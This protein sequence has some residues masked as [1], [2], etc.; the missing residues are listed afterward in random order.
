M[1]LDHIA[2]PVNNL[3]R[4]LDLFECAGG[5]TIITKTPDWAMIQIDGADHKLALLGPDSP[6]PSHVGY[7]ADNFQ[8]FVD[9]A[10]SKNRPVFAHRDG[11]FGFYYKGDAT[12]AILELVI[13]PSTPD[14]QEVSLK[15]QL[16]EALV[17]LASSEQLHPDEV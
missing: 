5:V 3:Y 10:K 11:S 7:R 2:I 1:T 8:E 4:T 14:G 9:F 13:Y 15:C 6:H 17:R 12:G 16:Q